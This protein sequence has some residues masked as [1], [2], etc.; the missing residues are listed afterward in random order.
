MF[1]LLL[2][3]LLFL[4]PLRCLALPCCLLLPVLVTRPS[5]AGAGPCNVVFFLY[6]F[7][8]LVGCDSCS[9]T[10]VGLLL[11]LMLFVAAVFVAVEMFALP[12]CLLLPLLVTRPSAA[13]A[14]P[15]NV[16][17]VCPPFFLR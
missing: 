9:S 15:C 6:A 14:G 2:L 5:A 4:L 12:C 16:V 8:I 1:L 17:V 10:D 11:R 13:G 3:M 7:V